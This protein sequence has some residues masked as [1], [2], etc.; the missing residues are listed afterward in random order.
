MLKWIE[1]LIKDGV[2]LNKQDDQGQTLLMKAT[3]Q[4]HF[5]ATVKLLENGADVLIKNDNLEDAYSLSMKNENKE[6]AR[7]IRSHLKEKLIRD[8]KPFSFKKLQES[9]YQKE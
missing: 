9:S 1:Q 3:E 5:P 6:I 2:D 8:R 4:G 7:L